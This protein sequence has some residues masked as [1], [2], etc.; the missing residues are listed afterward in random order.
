MFSVNRGNPASIRVSP[1]GICDGHSGTWADTSVFLFKIIPPIL[2][3]HLDP[4]ATH[5][6]VKGTG[7]H[8]TRHV[9]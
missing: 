4:N 1:R 9:L 7:H 8:E 5:M 6:K 2:H 3:T